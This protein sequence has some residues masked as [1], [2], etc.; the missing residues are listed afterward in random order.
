MNIE[1]TR[2]FQSFCGALV[3]MGLSACGAAQT[4]LANVPAH[5]SQTYERTT[6][7]SY[8]S[9]DHQKLDLYVPESPAAGNPVLVFFYGG[10][11]QEGQKETYQFVGET[12][13]ANGYF[14]AIPDYG[15]YP[16]VPF[17]D[18]VEDAAMSV[19]WV[20]ENIET[21]GGN[22]DNLLLSGHSAGAHIG[23]LVAVDE[24]YLQAQG[25]SPYIIQGFAGLAGPYDFTP[26]SED[27]KEMFGPPERYPQM[28]ASTFVNGNEPPMLLLHG[29]DDRHVK[30]ENLERLER[31]L[32]KEGVRV[33][34]HVYEG[35]DH[36]G[37][38]GALT[39]WLRDRKPVLED[40]LAFFARVTSE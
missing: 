39:A 34:S 35:M 13:A 38:V 32:K 40:M 20:Y 25:L 28:Q 19:A 18:F 30:I 16:A 22:P 17:P 26:Q 9:E 15:K 27:L 14:V 21:Y 3:V 33:E 37:M 29:T 23:A 2:I 5:L 36:V 12:F 7:I 4:W 11:W 8:G 1:I 10:R 6:G 24:S 31:A